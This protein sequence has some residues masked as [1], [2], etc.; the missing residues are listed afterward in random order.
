MS[1]VE[2]ELQMDKRMEDYSLKALHPSPSE[3][4][5]EISKAKQEVDT[6]PMT[7]DQYDL[8]DLTYESR[9][10]TISN[11]AIVQTLGWKPSKIKSHITKEM[12]AEYQIQQLKNVNK[13][14]YIPANLDIDLE[15]LPAYRSQRANEYDAERVRI[16]SEMARIRQLLIDKIDEYENA[17]LQ[18]YVSPETE[19]QLRVL[20]G[21]IQGLNAALTNKSFELDQATA[22]RDLSAREASQ[23][24]IDRSVIERRNEQ[25]KK[26]FVDELKRLNSGRMDV[27]M[28]PDETPDEY[29]QRLEDVGATTANIDAITQSAGIFFTDVLREK[30]L[31][32]LRNETEVL[33]FLKT[34]SPEERFQ[35]YENFELFKQKVQKVFGSSKVRAAQ[36][37]GAEF[38]RPISEILREFKDEI[39]AKLEQ[40]DED[41]KTA[42][43]HKTAQEYSD[44]HN[45]VVVPEAPIL[46]TLE[47]NTLQDKIL[48]WHRKKH[49][50]GK[51]QDNLLA[52]LQDPTIPVLKHHHRS[53]VKN[54]ENYD[55]LRR[56][57]DALRGI[58][59]ESKVETVDTQ[60][61]QYHR[62]IR[63]RIDRIMEEDPKRQNAVLQSEYEHL[64]QIS[65]AKTPEVLVLTAELFGVDLPALLAQL[66]GFPTIGAGLKRDKPKITPF[67]RLMIHTQRLFYDNDLIITSKT[68]TSITG[69]KKQK[70]SNAFVDLMFKILKGGTPSL[71]DIHSIS[72]HEKKLYDLLVYSSGLSKVVEPVGSGV[73]EHLRKRLEL[74]EGEVEAGNTN[75]AL[76]SEARQVLHSMAQ[77][78]MISRPSAVKHL[79]Q[80]SHFQR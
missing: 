43:F 22:R 77:M 9:L 45:P 33:E 72:D 5:V 35:L 29:R 66:N 8:R 14:V 61:E 37:K 58:V 49:I 73:K 70:V 56:Q 47:L 44:K 17:Q 53:S 1:L 32:I 39:L 80:L 67:G 19:G 64:L 52:Y 15:P 69:L 12:I 62:A 79:K 51:M 54:I 30:L 26:I 6:L 34:M 41:G 59:H 31:E 68:G 76:V 65:R 75:P 16:T 57:I 42:V 74:I 78:G 60:M 23:V 24:A 55:N 10:N 3:I 46:D 20:P 18:L 13:G 50:T 71:K 40:E 36:L 63:A 7:P 21:I 2:R 25:K 4:P 27:E 28:Q 38:E 48:T 11:N